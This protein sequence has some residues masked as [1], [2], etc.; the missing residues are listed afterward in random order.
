MKQYGTL[1]ALAVAVIFG[2]VA[3]I[4]ANQWLSTQGS[5]ET[6]IVPE[7]KSPVTKIGVSA[8]DLDIGSQLNE[9]TNQLVRWPKSTT[10]NV[11]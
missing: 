3:V 8:H 10:P 2:V 6:V 7:H 4:L 9:Q 11:T 1:I 5:E